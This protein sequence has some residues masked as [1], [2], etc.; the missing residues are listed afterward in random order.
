MH[1]ELSRYTNAYLGGVDI[2]LSAIYFKHAASVCPN[3][4]PFFNIDYL[5]SKSMLSG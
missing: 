1:T 5:I 2:R 3:A 4:F